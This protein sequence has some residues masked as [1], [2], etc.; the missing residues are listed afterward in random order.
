MLRMLTVSTSNGLPTS[1]SFNNTSPPAWLW[2]SMNPG[3]IVMPLA[4]NVCV[5]LRARALMSLVEPTAV[6]RPAATA[7][8]SAR[9]P[10]VSI[11]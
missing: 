11:V 5:P 9:G 8:A 10:R 4:S 2:Q 7:N 6:K 3:T 1:T